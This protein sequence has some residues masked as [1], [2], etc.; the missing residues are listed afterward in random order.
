MTKPI[1]YGGAAF[2]QSGVY[3]ASRT[4]VNPCG[5]YFDAGGMTL[6][7]WYA[8]MA[9][10][11]ILASGHRVDDELISESYSAADLMIAHER[12]ESRDE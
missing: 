12:K 11:G 5:A 4:E 10:H 8:G 9:L 2:P 3:D 1:D 7:Q 6:R